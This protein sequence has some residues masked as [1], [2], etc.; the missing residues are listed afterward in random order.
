MSFYTIASHP[1]PT[2]A[3]VIGYLSNNY[4]S[5]SVASGYWHNV[6]GT[7][8]H[9]Y[10]GANTTTYKLPTGY[11]VVLSMINSKARGGALAIDWRN[12]ASPKFY[13][14]NLHDDTQTFSWKGWV[15]IT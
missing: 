12:S 8:W 1:S 10:E 4:T 15:S 11:C 3:D 14:N 2:G 7:T 13:V 5:K 6:L 9:Y